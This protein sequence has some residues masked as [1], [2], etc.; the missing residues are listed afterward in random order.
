MKNLSL[1]FIALFLA[2][3]VWFA[4]SAPR[5]E[6]VYE[7]RF[8]APLSIVGMPREYLI[9]TPVPE[10]VSVRLRGR[11]SDLHSVSSQTLDVPVDL[12][13]IRQSGDVT[14][15]LRPQGVHT[16]PDIEVVAIDP[17]KVQFHVELIRQRAVPIRPL[18][19][20]QLPPGFH[21]GDPALS[22]DRALVSGPSSQILAMSEVGT[23]RIIMTGRTATFVQN[24][25]VVSDSPLVRV[26]APLTTQVTVPVLA[27]IGPNQPPATASPAASTTTAE[28][29]KKEEEPKP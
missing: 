6:R 12:G 29:K 26:V 11:A 23:E 27:E 4:V 3:V 1:K 16:P 20:G 9:T 28:Q 21:P 17:N 10:T 5:R 13:W 2:L 18:L 14:V 15:T 22:P 7:R 25:A 8:A 24:V 19:D